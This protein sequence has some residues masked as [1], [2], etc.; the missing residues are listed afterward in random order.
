MA[1][2]AGRQLCKKE[3]TVVVKVDNNSTV[4]AA[5]VIRSIEYMNG[6][7]KVLACVPRNADCYEVMVENIEIVENLLGTLKI[8]GQEYECRKIHDDTKTVSIMH[9]PSFVTDDQIRAKIEQLGVRIISRITRKKHRDSDVYDGTRIM[10]VKFND[11]IKSLPYTMKFSDGQMERYYRVI[12]SDQV[13]SCYR[14]AG[15]DHMARSCPDIQCRKCLQHGHLQYSCFMVQC[16]C[17]IYGSDSCTCDIMFQRNYDASRAGN[18][19]GRA[20][21]SNG[22]HET[23]SDNDG[24]DDDDGEE[25]VD[26]HVSD[27]QDTE[28]SSS[29]VQSSNGGMITRSQVSTPTPRHSNSTPEDTPVPARLRRKSDGFTVVRTNRRR[30]SGLGDYERGKKVQC[31]VSDNSHSSNGKCVSTVKFGASSV[32]TS[33]ERNGEINGEI[34]GERNQSSASNFSGIDDIQ[35][36]DTNDSPNLNATKNI[37][38][39]L[40]V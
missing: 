14:C 36:H 34:N 16:P 21:L 37:D 15:T 32:G 10:R 2:M 9:L 31:T 4:L 12:H 28:Q 33:G 27:S 7:G 20:C 11:N 30:K 38:G 35:M 22:E 26:S 29:G 13:K 19:N 40:Q 24:M 17:G 23:E 25:E 8:A 6:V 3:A 1:A 5:Q 39:N 18:D